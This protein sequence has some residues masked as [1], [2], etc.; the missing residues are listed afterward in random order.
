MFEDA[1]KVTLS[2]GEIDPERIARLSA[3]E[4][5]QVQLVDVREP[6]EW[7]GELGHI[8]GSTLYPLGHFLMAGPPEG[9]DP[10]R[11]LVIVC[12][13]GRR[14]ARAAAA[15]AFLG[16]RQAFNLTGGM[17]AWNEAGLLVSRDVP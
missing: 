3:E 14:S 1:R 5:A 17:I 7:V 6:H 4:R 16:Y 10:D 15:A 2:F 12:R 9:T 13:S 11:P 8:A